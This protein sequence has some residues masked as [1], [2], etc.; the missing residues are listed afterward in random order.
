MMTKK[1]SVSIGLR[2]SRLAEKPFLRAGAAAILL[3]LWTAGARA[4]YKPIPNY[5]GIN[6]G[7]QFRNDINNH[8]SGATPIAPRLV[9]LPFVQLPPETDGQLYWCKDCQAATP[10]QSG[11]SG[12]MALGRGGAWTCGGIAPLNG[13]LN[14]NNNRVINLAPNA[15]SGDALS[16]GQSHLNDLAT[17][18]AP[19]N[20]GANRLT[21]LAADAASG[22]ALSRSQSTLNSLAAPAASYAMNSQKLT[23]LGA[24]SASGDSLAYGQSGAL[25]N[26][27]NL[28]SNQLTNLSAA[29][30]S[31]DALGFGQAGAQL[32]PYAQPSLRCAGSNGQENSA[33]L[34][35]TKCSATAQNDLEI[36]FLI[37]NSAS[38][39]VTCPTGFTGTAQVLY[40]GFYTE[41][42]CY[43]IAGASEPSSYTVGLSASMLA[44]VE[45]AAV[46]NV[47]TT[48]PV[49]GWAGTYHTAEANFVIPA[50]G[51]V[52]PFDLG[53]VF[54]GNNTSTN[55][56]SAP[57]GG[58]SV[59]ADTSGFLNPTVWS[60]TAAPAS[61]TMTSTNLVNGWIGAQLSI[62][63]ALG[64]ASQPIIFNQAGAALNSLSG[65][66]NGSVPATLSGFNQD[67]DFNPVAPPYGADPTGVAPS[68]NALESA[69]LAAEAASTTGGAGTL[70]PALRIPA[71]KYKLNFPLVAYEAPSG[72]NP[73]YGAG[74]LT[75]TLE[76]SGR[77]PSIFTYP[78]QGGDYV[79]GL[80]TIAGAALVGTNPSLQFN[81]GK[82]WFLDVKD[83]VAGASVCAAPLSGLAAFTY[84]GF[85]NTTDTNGNTDTLVSG[86]N[87]E[88]PTFQLYYVV[89]GAFNGWLT[90]GGTLYKL[91][92][93]TVAGSTNYFYAISYDG[94]NIRLYIGTPGATSLAPIATQAATG[95][96]TEAVNEA[97]MIGGEVQYWPDDYASFSP[98]VGRLQEIRLSNTARYTGTIATVPNGALSGDSN[99][100]LLIHPTSGNVAPAKNG[101]A[102]TPFVKVDYDT[103][104]SVPND[105][106]PIWNASYYGN[107]DGITIRDLGT[108]GGD[109]GILLT[110]AANSTLENLN[111]SGFARSG[112]ALYNNDYNS[113]LNNINAGAGCGEADFAYSTSVRTSRNLSAGGGYYQFASAPPGFGTIINGIATGGSTA[114][115]NV[116]AQEGTSP[117]TESQFIGFQA[118]NE[119]GGNINSLEIPGD[120]GGGTLISEGSQWEGVGTGYAVKFDGANAPA[121]TFI[122][123]VFQAGTSA[124]AAIYT[125][126][127][128]AL[129]SNTQV[130]YGAPLT[131]NPQ[132]VTSA[133]AGNSTLAGVPSFQAGLNHLVVNKVSDPAA[134][135]ISVVGGTGSTA[136]GPYYVVCHDWNGGVTNVSPIS[137]TVANGPA[138]LTTSNYIN[139]AWN[140]PASGACEYWDIL[141]G[142]LTTA[143]ATNQPGNVLSFHDTGQATNAYAYPVRNTTGDVN[144]GTM[145]VSSGVSW[146]LP[147][148]VVNGASFYCPN[149]D[150]PANPPVACTSSGTKT[151]SWVHGL[152]NQWICAP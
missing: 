138:T 15:A 2:L 26:G 132:Y 59:L 117:Y 46:E 6:A 22:D 74:A 72:Y 87:N 118:D 53:V 38:V 61:A 16:Q 64:T 128:Q 106:M 98:F 125:T 10:C 49:D 9:T 63:P 115:A 3:I 113:V 56:L 4:Q 149:C 30:A 134:A 13:S 71:G 54:S 27:L 83:A 21:N 23:G 57:I 77:F 70:Y 111:F 112:L 41:E 66:A 107:A 90:V 60:C 135:T 143:V 142:N 137:N 82:P 24:G 37:L 130:L 150:P 85:F 110:Q 100:L 94:S 152:N 102:Q 88:S 14:A 65:A 116:Y 34:T 144:V 11:G 91:S 36:I 29:T 121:S 48:T 81:S 92:G 89:G 7:Q 52:N 31:G 104:G 19:Y 139:I 140:A 32:T 136:Y 44:N 151:G 127:P 141:K 35:A 40:P 119:N 42:A 96:V 123:D 67:G 120:G 147:A 95:T 86:G 105:W 39:T 47:N 145:M 17:A 133:N 126:G 50:T 75:T 114:I 51:A 69:Y 93:G 76:P 97:L 62:A 78:T 101:L 55:Y 68:D 131:N 58:K 20:M 33:S 28:N 8:L 80:G 124:P 45:F 18:T 79:T 5:V 108:S 146:P 99:T 73:I 129:L 43:K 109:M 1:A 25:L 12:A 122:G 84:E 148:S 103:Q